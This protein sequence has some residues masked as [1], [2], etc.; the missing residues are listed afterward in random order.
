MK[1]S[2]HK[3]C[4]ITLAIMI[5]TSLI[6]SAQ[7]DIV[8]NT[9]PLYYIDVNRPVKSTVHE[10]LDGKLN[11]QYEDKI[12]HW[13][14]IEL[15]IFNWKSEVVGVFELNKELGLNNYTI[16]LNA[17]YSFENDMIY[18]AEFRDEQNVKHEWHFKLTV[19]KPKEIAAN[20]F[21]NPIKL[22]CK[23]F[24]RENQVEFYGTVANG[25]SPYN[26]RWFVMNE[27][28]SDFLF[29]PKEET[30]NDGRT[31]VLQVDKSPAYFVVLDVTDAC[32]ANA[33]KM[34]LM[35]CDNRKKSRSTIMI[36]PLPL[37][38]QGNKVKNREIK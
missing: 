13:K 26:I 2:L 12:G 33:R 32:G 28:K 10:I 37:L 11:I 4:I 9:K 8:I 1:N 3:M 16:N 36:E 27:A 6:V 19:P 17:G 34:V 38:Q 15:K 35:G 7:T 21:V 20:I 14:E 23:R 5:G 24:G 29:Q 25:K 30:I 18:R 31:S 22:N